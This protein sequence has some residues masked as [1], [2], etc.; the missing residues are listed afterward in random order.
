MGF[1]TTVTRREMESV[2][3]FQGLGRKGEVG[4]RGLELLCVFGMI[5][6][7]SMST[8][9]VSVDQAASFRARV[10]KVVASLEMSYKRRLIVDVDVV[11]YRIFSFR[12]VFS[13]LRPRYCLD[14]EFFAFLRVSVL[15]LLKVERELKV[16][17]EGKWEGTYSTY[18]TYSKVHV[19]ARQKAEKR[20]NTE[21]R[22]WTPTTNEKLGLGISERE[23]ITFIGNHQIL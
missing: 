15:L 6:S 19:S 17:E 12:F 16:E 13:F 23:I 9:T 22:L 7:Y 18:S 1:W 4:K 14:D 10:V 8:Y 11:S 3:A 2:E 21:S 5:V 20:R